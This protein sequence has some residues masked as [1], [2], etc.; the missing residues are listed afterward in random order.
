[1]VRQ[2]IWTR[3]AYSKKIEIFEYW[4][5]KTNSL[6]YSKTLDRLFDKSLSL[7]AKFPHIGLATQVEHVR[8]K[9]VSRKYLLIY[10]ISYSNIHILAIWDSR[11][12]P[13]DFDRILGLYE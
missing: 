11:Q 8:V 6:S 4:N 5:Q 10:K 9:V 13:E 12:N 2:V 3:L 7:L 1:M